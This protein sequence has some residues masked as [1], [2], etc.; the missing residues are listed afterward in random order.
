MPFRRYPSSTFRYLERPR[1]RWEPPSLDSSASPDRSP[2]PRSRD[3]T[4]EMKR[5][6]VDLEAGGCLRV[7]S[8]IPSFL[9]LVHTLAHRELFGKDIEALSLT[10]PKTWCLSISPYPLPC[11]LFLS[12][13]LGSTLDLDRE[14]GDRHLGSKD[15][16]HKHM[17][18]DQG[19]IFR[20]ERERERRLSWIHTLRD[21]QGHRP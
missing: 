3:T 21:G 15:I 1:S 20:Q 13:S 4:R 10:R 6:S 12:S 18:H 2:R 11:L 17:P 7:L 8:S 16:S 5:Y 19:R 9:T 14:V